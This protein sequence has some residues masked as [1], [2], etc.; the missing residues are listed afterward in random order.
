MPKAEF[1]TALAALSPATWWKCDEAS[2]L[3]QDSSGN[4][5]H[6]G[7]VINGGSTYSVDGVA[8]FSGWHGIQCVAASNQVFRRLAAGGVDSTTALSF[9]CFFKLTAVMSGLTVLMSY[10]GIPSS[11]NGYHLCGRTD[12]QKLQV[13]KTSNLGNNTN[14]A[15]TTDVLEQDVW[16]F[17]VCTYGTTNGWRMYLDKVLQ[18]AGSEQA[19]APVAPADGHAVHGRYKDGSYGVSAVIAEAFHVASELTSGDVSVL[20]LA[21]R[22]EI[23]LAGGG[24]GL[25]LGL[26]SD[27]GRLVSK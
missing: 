18:T 22:P 10:G 16:Y 2:G 11:S 19:T 27:T 12:S 7:Q 20:A 4:G 9:G 13:Q 21:A 5:R 6:I 26:S 23:V 8:G 17:I 3:P 14:Y 1:H 25:G 15:T 24:L